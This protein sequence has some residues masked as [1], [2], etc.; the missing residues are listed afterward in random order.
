MK[1]AILLVQSEPEAARALVEYFRGQRATVTHVNTVSEA[2]ALIG[3]LHPRLVVLDLHLEGSDWIQLIQW[4]QVRL[5]QSRV[6]ITNKYPDLRR[7]LMAKKLGCSVFLRQPFT[8]VWIERALQQLEQETPER[9]SAQFA[10]PR[11]RLPVTAKIILPF[12]LMALVFVLGAAYLISRYVS[13]SVN[14]RF[15]RQ[16]IDAATL[17]RCGNRAPA[18]VADRGQRAGERRRTA[19]AARSERALAAPRERDRRIRRHAR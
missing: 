8:P 2:M 16:L 3:E 5:P 10:L 12:A 15:Q 7:E 11:V 4:V 9:V 6:L 19:L 14:D 1:Q 18:G 13:D 17:R